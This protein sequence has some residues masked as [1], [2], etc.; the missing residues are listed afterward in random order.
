[1][2]G[3]AALRIMYICARWGENDWLF[4]LRRWNDEREQAL[5]AVFG[6]LDPALV[7][8]MLGIGREGKGRKRKERDGL[9]GWGR[10]CW[11]AGDCRLYVFEAD[12]CR[13]I[14][15]RSGVECIAPGR[16]LLDIWA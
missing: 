5:D 2:D 3:L 4:P 12:T 16:W 10:N 9:G 6:S 1:M 15:V 14:D 13:W 7:A 11:L 8:R